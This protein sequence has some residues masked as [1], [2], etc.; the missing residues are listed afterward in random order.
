MRT[1]MIV[2]IREMTRK[3]TKKKM[4]PELRERKA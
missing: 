3:K 1:M 2:T 4:T